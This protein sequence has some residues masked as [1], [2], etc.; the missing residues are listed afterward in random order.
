MRLLIWGTGRL[1]GKVVGRWIK[2]DDIIGF[3]DNKLTNEEYM[4][5]KVYKPSAI[6]NLDYDALVVCNLF[7]QEIY[8]QCLSLQLDMTKNIYLYNNFQLQDLNEDYEFVEAMLGKEYA[9]IVQKRY[10]VVRGTEAYGDLCIEDTKFNGQNYIDTDYVRIKCF[11]LVVKEIRK[12]KLKGAVAE[13]GVFRGEFA[14][15]INHAF[16]DSKLY[17]F[18]T[19]EGFNASEALNEVR[20]GNA[21]DSFIEAY[22]NTDIKIVLDRMTY[23]DNVIIRQGFFPQTAEGIKEEFIF[24]SIDMDFEESIYEGIK[25]FYPKTVEG[26]YIFVHDYNSSLRGVEKAI[27]RYERE[28]GIVLHKMPICDANGT[29]VICK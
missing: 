16:P 24:S 3:V 5:K 22:K 8:E 15:Y 12:R 21:T 6:R 1:T 17:L 9:D 28:V 7:S 19:F 11:E 25:Y 20:N 23:L 18:D 26:G 13:A 27:D 14:Q 10:H 4:G 2:L 29:L